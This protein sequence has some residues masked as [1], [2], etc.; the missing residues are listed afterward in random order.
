MEL[1][2]NLHDYNNLHGTNYQTKEELLEHEADKSV[3]VYLLHRSRQSLEA[4]FLTA[5]DQCEK[6]EQTAKAIVPEKHRPFLWD[7]ID[8]CRNRD[9][10]KHASSE[11]LEWRTLRLRAAY[12]SMKKHLTT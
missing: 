8:H 1:E 7:I 5:L 2:I 6:I 9:M 11:T 10:I 12:D 4:N 3:A